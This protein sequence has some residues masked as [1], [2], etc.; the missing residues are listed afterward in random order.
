MIFC[1]EFDQRF[2]RFGESF[3]YYDYN[4]P[5]SLPAELER[6]FDLVVADPPFLSD[7]CLRKTAQSVQFLTNKRILLCTGMYKS[8]AVYVS[9]NF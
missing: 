2:S 7:D 6:S 4:E 3:V 9:N 8:A 1:L 5:L